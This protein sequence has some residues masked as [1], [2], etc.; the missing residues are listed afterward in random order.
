MY[1]V[2]GS[3]LQRQLISAVQGVRFA[4][5]QSTVQLLVCKAWRVNSSHKT[6]QQNYNKEPKGYK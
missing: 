4:T 2:I 6:I 5:H 3:Y 1:N